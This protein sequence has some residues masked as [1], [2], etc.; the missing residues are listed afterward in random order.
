MAGAIQAVVAKA[1]AIDLLSARGVGILL[2]AL[3][4]FQIANGTVC[5]IYNI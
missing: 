1:C 5:V 3:L 2:S 4:A